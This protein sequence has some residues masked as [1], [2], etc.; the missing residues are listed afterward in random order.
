[1]FTVK[2]DITVR[3]VRHDGKTALYVLAQHDQHAAVN[4]LYDRCA[5]SDEAL[6]R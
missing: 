5:D 2:C 1:M 4:K 3:A 6:A